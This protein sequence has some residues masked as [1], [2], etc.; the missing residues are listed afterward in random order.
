MR[1]SRPFLLSLGLLPALANAEIS[2]TYDWEVRNTYVGI[3]GEVA[4]QQTFL[5]QGSDQTSSSRLIGHGTTVLDF[6]TFPSPDGATGSG[7]TPDIRVQAQA[8]GRDFRVETTIEHVRS[9]TQ[10]EC[11]GVSLNNSIWSARWS[12]NA[13]ASILDRVTISGD[14]ALDG[15]AGSF[16]LPI[17]LTGQINLDQD[18]FF[19]MATQPTLSVITRD[20]NGT[21]T[22]G[23]QR[24]YPNTWSRLRPPVDVSIDESFGLVIPF[25]F[26]EGFDLITGL[27]SGVSAIVSS[28][29]NLFELT[30]LLASSDFAN[31]VHYDPFANFMVDSDGD[32]VPDAAIDP[33]ILQISSSD[34]IDYLNDVTV[35]PV[36]AAVW[37]FGS[38]LVGLI[39]IAR[40]KV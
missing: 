11:N 33:A 14:A 26:N 35:I 5:S 28:S 7:P 2:S 34:G 1:L 29:G 17:E 24:T 20:L 31:T 40:R 25:V 22:A 19:G 9:C 36:P 15:M 6:D 10:T 37:L 27:T 18:H 30:N 3:I 4:D 39:G 12:A 32:G 38:G 8:T 16:F 21:R 23:V 13:R